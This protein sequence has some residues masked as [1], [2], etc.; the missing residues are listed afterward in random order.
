VFYRAYN[1]RKRYLYDILEEKEMMNKMN[2]MMYK[3]VWFVM[4]SVTTL[5]VMDVLSY[6]IDIMN[7][8]DWFVL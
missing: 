1:E 7:I 5:V 4:V 8:S 2:D 6:V 3:V